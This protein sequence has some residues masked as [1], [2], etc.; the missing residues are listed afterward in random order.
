MGTVASTRQSLKPE[1]ADRAVFAA[2]KDAREAPFA[3]EIIETLR[4]SQVSAEEVR[5]A[6]WRLISQNV[7]ELA[8]DHRLK[9][10]RALIHR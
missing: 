4:A 6:I 1:T 8:P 10:L 2:I 5:R 9:V 7:I 3:H